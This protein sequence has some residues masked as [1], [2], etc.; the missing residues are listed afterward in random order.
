MAKGKKNADVQ[1]LLPT[2]DLG[3]HINAR[4][5]PPPP[6]TDTRTGKSDHWGRS[7]PMRCSVGERAW[8]RGPR[9]PVPG[10]PHATDT[11]PGCHTP[12][13]THT[14]HARGYDVPPPPRRAG[15]RTLRLS[16][17]RKPQR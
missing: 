16:C 13:T 8:R 9:G 4:G 6:G 1:K 3:S 7:A 12:C 14:P 11:R 5:E 15:H 17:A 2:L 10:R